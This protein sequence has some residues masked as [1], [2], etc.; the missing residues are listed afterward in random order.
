MNAKVLAFLTAVACLGHTGPA[1]ALDLSSVVGDYRVTSWAGGDGITLGEVRS[2]A[3]DRDGYLWIASDA[4]LIRFDGLRFTRADIVVDPWRLPASPTR[5]V[6]VARDGSLW[7]GYGDRQGI[8][9]LEN[10]EVREIHLRNRIPGLVNAISE[11]RGGTLWA[12]HDNGLYRFRDGRWDAISLPG[13]ERGPRVLD[14]HEDRAGT[15][16]VATTSGLYRRP[17]GGRFEPA[18]HGR[19]AAR[20][21]SED[22][23]GRIWVTDDTA[24]FRRADAA[25]RNP[26]F[27]ARGM[28]LFHDSRGNLWVTTI[29]QGLWQVRAAERGDAAPT[30][31]R[32]TAQTGLVSDESSAIF[33]DRDGN[34]WVGSIQGLNRLTPHRVMSLG[35]LGVV[36]ALALGVDGKAW[37]GTTTGL[38]ELT[39]VAAHAPGQRRV[40]STT[41]IRALHTDR[42][43][44]V[45]AATG[46]GLHK[47][48]GGRLVKASSGGRRLR[49][50]TSIASDRDG[51]LWICDEAE[52]LV[53]VARG[54]VQPAADSI[55]DGVAAAP[56]LVYIDRN[57]RLW[58]AFKG[59]TVRALDRD[60][61]IFEYG[62][63]EGLSHQNVYTFHHDRWGDMWIGGNQ[64]LS[65]LRGTRF[66][67][68]TFHNE[69]L[70]RSVTGITDDET[71]DLWVALSFFGFIRLDHNAVSHAIDDASYRPR[72]R[73][74]NTSSGAGYPDSFF[75]NSSRMGPGHTMWFVTSR[76]LAVFDP[77]EMRGKRDG[78]PGPPRIEGVTV[79][80][81]RFGPTDALALPPRTNRLRIDYTVVSLSSLERVRFRYRLDGFDTEWVDGTGP[82]QAFYTNLPPG[83]YRFRLQASTNAAE[84]NDAEA[85]WVF[86]IQPMFYQT[87]WFYFLCG[88]GLLL[89]GIGAWQLRI[90]QVRKELALVFGERLRLSRE[91]HD[92]LLQ[93]LFGIALQLDVAARHLQGSASPVLAQLLRLRR[94]TEE[95]ISEARRS[96]WDL[97]S[98]ALERRDLV[99]A[100]RETGD[101]LTAGK[102]PF[103]LSVTGTPRPCPARLE[104][105][106]LRIGHEAIMNAVRHADARQVEMEIG[107]TDDTLR[108]RVVDNGRGLDAGQT[109]DADVY[110]HYG[111]S[112]MKE[113]A[114]DAGGRFTITS[115]P[116]AGVQVIAEFP[117]NPAA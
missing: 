109:P 97:R 36:Q 81:R 93:S 91:M 86:S 117:L 72:Y 89:C 49:Q 116:G 3:Q 88:L 22:Q 44:T 61:R 102:V 13:A 92:T 41:S 45:W 16:W 100:L 30:V 107:F 67:T 54:R 53:R 25:E 32:A 71:G 75:N 82:R 2:I 55:T 56:T 62:S 40:V 108:L 28:G 63:G 99:T 27:E 7:V 24:G 59:G 84:W 10:G 101:R 5:A 21:I 90:R 64:G 87:R 115:A 66:H 15:L 52:G 60:G 39:G 79:D 110:G 69:V 33:E 106:V 38:I 34:I 70:G 43:G 95:Y 26:L 103:V 31:R 78:A 73:V 51:T 37:V 74:Y 105:Q 58:I 9:R 83:D 98:Q 20:G 23:F 46:E 57:D 111:L 8:Y 68:F 6:Y 35:D 4:G 104:T 29:G 1:A 50:V 94:Q 18:P 47:V 114:A 48:L 77:H 65:Q 113:R 112:S 85:D 17:A 96:I 19:S 11:D 76:G 80:E 14:L 12:G 42:N